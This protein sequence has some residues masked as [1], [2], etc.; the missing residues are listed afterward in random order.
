MGA[1]FAIGAACFLVGPLVGYATLVGARA[2][3][4]TFFVGSVLFTLG[5]LVQ[6]RL[7]SRERGSS[8]VGRATWRTAWVQSVGTLLFNFMTL[9]ALSVALSSPKYNVLVW[10]PN[11]LGSICFLISGAI[12]YLSSPRRGWLPERRH[13]GWWEPV[14]NLLGC[15][16]FGVSAVAG[17]VVSSSGTM[18]SA[19]TANWTTSLGAACFLACALAALSLG[20]TLKAPRLR[21]LRAAVARELEQWGAVL[22]ADIANLGR[23]VE[24]ELGQ[25]K[26]VVRADIERTE[27]ALAQA[28]GPT[29]VPHR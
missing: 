21:R 10:P 12:F 16:L 24:H 28:P 2:D 25:V 6:C 15:A 27:L 1:F 11:A 18:V 20:Q 4:F 14:L 3:A 8:A 19:G 13:E 5:G 26:L 17:L 29:A 7:A 22:D 23:A 9:Q